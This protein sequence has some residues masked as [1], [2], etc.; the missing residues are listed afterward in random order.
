MPTNPHGT[1]ILTGANGGLG[2]SIVSQITTSP[3]LSL[4]YH[5]IYCVRN[6]NSCPSLNTAL[7]S[8]STHSHSKYSLD[9]SDLASV[10][11]VARD[12]NG[13]VAAGVI[14]RIH[15]LVLNAGFEEFTSDTHTADGFDMAF[16]ANYLGH[17][18]MT[19]LL[20]ESMDRERGRVVW[21]SSWVHK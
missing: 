19:V 18:L 4:S 21:L 16:A 10:R 11:D 8:H 20:L 1:I 5:G 15:A 12:I 2:T 6:T 17:W 13:Q 14:P 3:S 7:T 9:L